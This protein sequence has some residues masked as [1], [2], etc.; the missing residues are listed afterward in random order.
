MALRFEGLS[1]AE[2]GE[3]LDIRKSTLHY[4]LRDIPLTDAQQGR[5]EQRRQLAVR[6]LKEWVGAQSK[7]I[8]HEKCSRGGKVAWERHREKIQCVLDEGRLAAHL[9]YRKDELPIKAALEKL[10]DKKFHKE[11]IGK[12]VMDFA[13]D[14]YL[15]EYTADY[16]HGTFDLVRRF[17][18]VADDPRRKVAYLNVRRLGAPTRQR[19]EAIDVEIKDY[20]GVA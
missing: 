2:I 11:I 7:E 10:Y 8:L 17:E 12:R 15:I 9:A 14:D 5:L 19:L 13:S 18:D 16:T 4:M 3:L 1:Y 20:L 6:A